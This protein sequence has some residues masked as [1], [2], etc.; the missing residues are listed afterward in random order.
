MPSPSPTS[1]VDAPN[2]NAALFA[3][4][5]QATAQPDAWRATDGD[6]QALLIGVCAEAP[7][8]AVVLAH[9]LMPLWSVIV[10]LRQPR[11]KR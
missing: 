11:A 5:A 10:P 7:A 4:A 6:G 1:A 9:A 2:R 8:P 3:L